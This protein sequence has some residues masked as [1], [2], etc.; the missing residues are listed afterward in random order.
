MYAP[1]IF[2]LTFQLSGDLDVPGSRIVLHSGDSYPQDITWVLL[3]P[4]LIQPATEIARPIDYR[5]FL[6]IQHRLLFVRYISMWS[7]ERK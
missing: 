1:L 7:S 3:P 2:L 4:C 5:P 6:P